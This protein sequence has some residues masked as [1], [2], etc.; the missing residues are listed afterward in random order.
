METGLI[1]GSLGRE[2]AV[3]PPAASV[4]LKLL[5]RHQIEPIERAL[6]YSPVRVPQAQPDAAHGRT[7]GI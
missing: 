1:A 5:A 2:D 4:E 3:D 6:V 7:V